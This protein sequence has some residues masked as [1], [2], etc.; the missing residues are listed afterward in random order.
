MT[1][2]FFTLVHPGMFCFKHEDGMNKRF[3][4]TIYIRAKCGTLAVRLP[5]KATP[6]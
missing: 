5:P 2:G 3:M 6:I 4:R 1:F